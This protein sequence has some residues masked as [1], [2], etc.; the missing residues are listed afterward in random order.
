[1]R[2]RRSR[3]RG[4]GPFASDPMS[5][6]LRMGTLLIV[7]GLIYSWGSKPQSWKWLETQSGAQSANEERD[8]EDALAQAGP[9]TDA[10]KAATPSVAGGETVVPAP[11]DLDKSEWEKSQTLFEAV[12]DKTTLAHEEM[13]AYWRCMK[14]ARAQTF[15]EMERRAARDVPYA[16]F[17]EEPEKYRGRMIRLRLHIMQLIDWDAHENSAGVKHV[18]EAWGWTDRSNFL[19]V[20]VFSELPS[21][22]KLGERLHEEGEFVG[23]FLKDMAFQAL[24]RNRAAPLLVGRMQRVTSAPA[25]LVAPSD[26]NWIWLG[27]AVFVAIGFSAAW[28]RFARGRRSATVVAPSPAD[29]V[30]MEEWFRNEGGPPADPAHHGDA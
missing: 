17:M 20:C 18:Y 1:M 27:A 16:R 11:T 22:M 6:L 12:S 29:E 15:A 3:N 5:A 4:F 26:W 13:P 19:Y 23:Y 7:L 21:E 9:A 28:L 2:R 25:P 30:E 14:W 24:N 8:L 10:K